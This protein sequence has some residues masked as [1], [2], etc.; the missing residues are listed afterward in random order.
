[1]R[2]LVTGATGFIGSHVALHARQQGF[3]V[4][5]AGQRNT[6]AERARHHYLES[7]GIEVV[8]GVL[9]DPDIAA[10][11]VSGCD[12]VIHLAA[13]QHEANVPDSYFHEVNV[14]G[15]RTLLEA[16]RTACVRRFVYGSTI[17]IYGSAERGVLDENSPPRPENIYGRTKLEAEQLVRAAHG[18]SIATTVIRISETYGPGDHRLLKL[19]RT[20]SSGTFMMIGAG[21]NRRQVIHV[22]D[23]VAGLLLSSTHPA[24]AGETFILAGQEVMTTREMVDSI[25]RAMGRAT[26]RGRI[27][28]LPVLASAVAM[29]TLLRPIGIQPPLHRRRLDFFRKSFLFSTVKA[30]N[31]LGFTPQVLFAQGARETAE[32]YRS[33]G[34]L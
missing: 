2:L 32:W 23:V 7:A 10:T 6:A 27:P 18:Q 12:A 26:P 1:M 19:F 22:H 24:A 4:A 16:S 13:A 20:I 28:L 21:D 25:A 29:E 34:E 15:T 5:A 11:M 14:A 17:G 33:K 9:Q 31:V 30:R 8:E 3:D